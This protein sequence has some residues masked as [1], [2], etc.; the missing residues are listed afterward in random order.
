MHFDAASGAV[1]EAQLQCFGLNSCRISLGD[2]SNFR[3]FSLLLAAPLA[4]CEQLHL[5]EGRGFHRRFH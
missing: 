4:R 1:S 3:I 2:G 5:R